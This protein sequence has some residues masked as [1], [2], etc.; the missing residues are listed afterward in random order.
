MVGK[1]TCGKGDTG[2]TTNA[3]APVS[4]TAAVRSVVATGR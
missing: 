2:S 3:M 1:S 4:I